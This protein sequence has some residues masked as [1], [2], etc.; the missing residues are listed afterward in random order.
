M[1]DTV[2]GDAFFGESMA[3]LPAIAGNPHITLPLGTVDGL[4]LGISLVG[5]RGEDHTLLR[6][7]HR[8]EAL[9]RGGP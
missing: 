4:P 5:R 2:N 3:S 7:A 8:L 6:I 1:I 9:H